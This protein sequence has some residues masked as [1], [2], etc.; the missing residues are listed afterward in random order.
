MTEQQTERFVAA[1]DATRVEQRPEFVAELGQR[2]REEAA[3]SA[4]TAIVLT[5]DQ[6]EPVRTNLV[7]YLQEQPY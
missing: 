1:L 2:I 3:S 6:R 7:D 5:D 4:D